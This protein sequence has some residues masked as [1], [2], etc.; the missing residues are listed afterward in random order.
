[1]SLGGAP[2]ARRVEDLLQKGGNAN[3]L[4][5]ECSVGFLVLRGAR[6]GEAITVEAQAGRHLPDDRPLDGEQR[7][8]LVRAGLR[9]AHA[10][11]LF[12]GRWPVRSAEDATRIVGQA[13]ALLDDVY[14]R[15]PSDPVRARLDLEERPA[16]DDADVVGAMTQLSKAR[17]TASRNRVY[18]ALCRA[19]LVLPVAGDAAPEDAAP[20]EPRAMD[21]LGGAAIAAIFTDWDTFDRYAPRGLPAVL[22][23]GFDVFPV[24][25]AARV[26]SVLINPRGRVGGELYAHEVASIAEGIGRL[27]GES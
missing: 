24:L 21:E 10:G 2:L 26:G 11:D 23:Q 16:L 1:M 13:L 6:G 15:P 25:H 4:V 20:F 17:D 7:Q 18:M 8:R 14:R 19:L 9:Q 27:R 22:R 12:R 5:M 3:R